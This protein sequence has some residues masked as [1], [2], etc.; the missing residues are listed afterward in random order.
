VALLDAAHPGAGATGRNAG[1]LL[2]ESE[3]YGAAASRH[4]ETA[5]R[6][7]RNAGLATRLLI[8][9]LV[10]ADKGSVDL[11]WCGSVRLASDAA[12][13]AS[14]SASAAAG[15]D[16]VARRT[17]DRVAERGH[18]QS[19]RDA[20]VDRGDA[21]VHPLRLLARVLDEATRLGAVVHHRTRVE[22][23]RAVEH[24]V[25]IETDRGT[26][27]AARVVL[28]NNASA[29]LLLPAARPVRPVRGQALAAQVH[30][31][32]RWRRPVY[33]THGGD[34]WRSLPGGR[35]LLGGLRRLRTREENTRDPNP[36]EVLQIA[37][38]AF[39][40]DL[41]GRDAIVHVTH[42]W[43][44]TMGFTPDGLPWVGR[45]PG[46][47]RVAIIAGMNGH[48]MGWAPALAKDLTDHLAGGAPPPPFD[49]GR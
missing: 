27:R 11:R 3:C 29:R 43:A 19:Y 10:G 5:A 7:L 22:R 6:A 45:M 1:L 38:H 36:T 28:A 13:S 35:V 40:R 12:E 15:L 24:H 14:F 37:L 21:V 8:R 34:Y 42:E 39:L 47:A 26:I 31:S 41:V 48:G 49:P 16:W 32:P 9:D 33:A 2:A 46:A 18:S 23:L 20:L 4:G 44:G 17:L 30:P 25:E